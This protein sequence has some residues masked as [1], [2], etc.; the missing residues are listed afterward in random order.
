[1]S[2]LLEALNTVELWWWQLPNYGRWFFATVP[3]AILIGL[4]GGVFS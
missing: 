2:I 4:A 3:T 1:V